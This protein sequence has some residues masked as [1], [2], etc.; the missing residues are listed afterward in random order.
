MNPILIF[1]RNGV[2]F[3]HVILEADTLAKARA[4]M[5]LSVIQVDVS[6]CVYVEVFA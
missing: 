1:C 4:A 2:R 3:A 5:R 6:G